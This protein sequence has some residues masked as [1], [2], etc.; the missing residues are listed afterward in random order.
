VS[1][2]IVQVDAFTKTPFRGNPAAI[3]V[4]KKPGEEHWMRSLALEMNLSETA[5][6]HPEEDGYRLRWFTPAVEVKL[7]GHAT[8]AAAHVLWED[9]IVERSAPCRFHTLSG[10]LVA[11]REGDWIRVAFPQEHTQDIPV[12]PEL[13]DAAGAPVA[14]AA[15]GERLQY[16]VLELEDEDAVR[17]LQPDIRGFLASAHKGI[18]ATARA[19]SEGVDIVSRFFAP[20]MGVDEDPVTG[21]AHCVLGAYWRP[22]LGQ[23]RIAAYQASP[24]GGDIRITFGE[25]VVYLAG[26]AVTVM[27]GT[28]V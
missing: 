5:Y 14:N 13:A 7:C 19:S 9:G 11:E 12:P 15:A 26:Q 22:R 18:I 23:D 24:R 10:E 8:I 27:R 1:Q 25:G 20:A 17:N 6:V 2:S 4:L 16:I 28:L 21:S 3:C